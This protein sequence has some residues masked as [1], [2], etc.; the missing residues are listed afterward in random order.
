MGGRGGKGVAAKTLATAIG[1]MEKPVVTQSHRGKSFQRNVLSAV[2]QAHSGRWAW[3][4]EQ[5]Q[6]SF[7]EFPA[8][9]WPIALQ[10]PE[11]LARRS[12]SRLF[13]IQAC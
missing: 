5:D 13:V 10:A 12:I 4:A 2:R 7:L 3:G 6:A 9:A 1:A 8:Q 11:G